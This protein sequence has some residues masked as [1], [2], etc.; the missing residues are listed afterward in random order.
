[1]DVEALK[2]DLLRAEQ[3]GTKARKLLQE[4]LQSC[5][6]TP[7]AGMEVIPELFRMIRDVQ[8]TEQHVL[9]RQEELQSILE[10]LKSIKKPH[11]Q[12]LNVK[13]LKQTCIL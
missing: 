13:F 11:G 1:M 2:N 4:E 7:G 3:A 10:K 9:D 8:R 5:G 12:C 6:L